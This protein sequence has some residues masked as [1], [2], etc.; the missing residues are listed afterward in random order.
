[1]GLSA[2]PRTFGPVFAISDGSSAIRYAYRDVSKSTDHPPS[3]TPVDLLLASL[4]ACILKSVRWSAEQRGATPLPFTV[5]VTGIKAGDE[6][7]RLGSVEITVI[8]KPVA[9]QNSIDAV[10]K[11]AKAICTVSNSLNSDITVSVQ[12]EDT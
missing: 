6:P 5:S 3:H 7:S 1:M 4:A 12:T 2:K 10:V 8:G 9:D 11:Q